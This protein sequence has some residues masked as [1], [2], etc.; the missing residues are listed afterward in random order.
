MSGVIL[1]TNDDGFRINKPIMFQR[2]PDYSEAMIRAIWEKF[3]ESGD[4]SLRSWVLMD[5]SLE[6]DQISEKD[7]G[8]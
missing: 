8:K 3:S 1:N 4:L 5:G 6:S 7:N 2:Y